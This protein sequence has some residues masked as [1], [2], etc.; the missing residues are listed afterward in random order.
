MSTFMLSRHSLTLKDWCKVK[1]DSTKRFSAN[2]FLKVYCTLQTSR[3]NNKRDRNTFVKNMNAGDS[4]GS[5]TET[6]T[7]STVT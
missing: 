6:T 1:S 2:G 5:K 4:N 7:D 3:S